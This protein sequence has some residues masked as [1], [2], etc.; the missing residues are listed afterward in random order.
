MEKRIKILMD[1]IG[2]V[3]V[4][5]EDT[6]KHIIAALLSNGHVLI[7]DVP[8]VGKTR[9]VSALAA[10]LNGKFNRIQ[11]TP[12]IMPSDITGFSALD[13]VTG[14]LKYHEGAAVCNFLLADEINRASSKSQS[15]LLEVME[16]HQITMDG[17]TII[18]PSPFMV[19]ATQNHIETYGTYHLPEAQMDRFLMRVSMG[20]PTKQEE[21]DILDVQSKS[22]GEIT[23]VM[24]LED[25]VQLQK[26]VEAVQ[27]T[28]KIKR[29]IVDIAD[30]SRNSQDI[31]LGISP[32]GSIALLKISKAMAFIND[33]N[34]VLPDDVKSVASIVLAHRITMSA[35]G[36]AKFENE[37]KMIE[38]IMNNVE[39]PI[40]DE[41]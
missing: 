32:R 39:V 16:E 10:S 2:K 15:S 40:Y 38:H 36:R 23:A 3:I 18:L 14:E 35:N 22:V 4:G 5:K 20:Y 29:Y 7:E 28:N 24:S 37:Y 21:M 11:L 25:I 19:L 34:Y 9:L 13:K 8:G 31:S 33:R 6:I 41:V 27:V 17:K 1:N 26:E 12:D 30:Y